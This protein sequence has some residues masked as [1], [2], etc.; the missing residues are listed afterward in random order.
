M[1]D[2]RGVFHAAYII[3][4]IVYGGYAL[5]IWMRAKR[6][7]EK[8]AETERQSGDPATRPAR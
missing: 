4:V 1:D 7:R 8:L 3:A 2:T 6:L 5:T